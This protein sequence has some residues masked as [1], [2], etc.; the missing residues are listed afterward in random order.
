MAGPIKQ[1]CNLKTVKNAGKIEA[2]VKIFLIKTPNLT[3]I[4]HWACVKMDI[5]RQQT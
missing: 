2:E 4:P 1:E 3:R 5:A